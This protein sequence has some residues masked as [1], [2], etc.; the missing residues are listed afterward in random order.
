MSG[1]PAWLRVRAPSPREEEGMRAVRDVVSRYRL[2][3]VCQGAICPNAAECWGKRTAT[4]MLLGQVCTR[5][6]RFCAVPTGNPGG[7]LDREEPARLAAALAEL[8]LSYVVLTSVDRDDLADGGA[9]LFAEAIRTIKDRSPGVKVEV[10]VPDFCGN[11]KAIA[12]VAEAGA[13]VIG[14][15]LET[16]RRL[17]PSLRDRR[18]GYDLSL[19]VLSRFKDLAPK[20]LVKS[21]LMLGLGERREE[22]LAALHDL[23]EAGVDAVTLGQYLRP[24]RSAF[25]VARYLP[26]KEFDE[27]AKTA[28]EMGFHSVIAGPLVRSSY[29]AAAL[30]EG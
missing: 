4:F 7:A 29:H 11:D 15:N 27:L 6:C 14:H 3:T 30:F 19:R 1:Q 20:S 17:T 28:R 12:T 22:V 25:P 24:T 18:A 21:S 5:T 8:D 13:D 23:G 10:L 2:A 16:V 9:S 26:P